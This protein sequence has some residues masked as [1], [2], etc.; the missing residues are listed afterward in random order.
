MSSK[1]HNIANLFGLVSTGVDRLYGF[2]DTKAYKLD[3]NG[4]RIT[5]R[6]FTRSGVLQG[7]NGA[8]YNGNFQS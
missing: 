6:D 4:G 7:I 3:R 5:L 8:A 2:A 1:P